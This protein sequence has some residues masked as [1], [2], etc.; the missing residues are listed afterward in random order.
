M[1]SRWISRNSFISR[2][3]RI[4]TSTTPVDDAA[5]P[6]GV[7]PPFDPESL[8]DLFVVDVAV[9]VLLLDVVVEGFVFLVVADEFFEIKT[10]FVARNEAGG[11]WMAG[12][13]WA[14]AVGAMA[15]EMENGN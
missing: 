11:G 6:A 7:V 8:A 13:T 12:L 4:V 1:C 3:D 2:R 10:L 14:C 15:L 5:P 9:L